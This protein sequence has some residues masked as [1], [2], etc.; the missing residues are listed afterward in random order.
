MSSLFPFISLPRKRWIDRIEKKSRIDI[1]DLD[2]HMP[3][4]ERNGYSENNSVLSGSPRRNNR[5]KSLE[6]DLGQSPE[7][8]FIEGS[9]SDS[10]SRSEM[11]VR[12]PNLNSKPYPNLNSKPNLNPDIDFNISSC[13]NPTPTSSPNPSP[14]PNSNSNCNPHKSP[15]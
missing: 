6:F 9:A 1:V 4:D 15:L 8:D 14:K 5:K 10:P 7:T 13:P 3:I 12:K 2:D 11:C